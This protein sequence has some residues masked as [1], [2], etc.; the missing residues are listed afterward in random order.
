MKIIGWTLGIIILLI[1]MGVLGHRSFR[2]WQERRLGAQANALVTEGDLKRASLDARRILQINPESAEGC[3]IMARI[4]ERGGSRTA[5]EWRRRVVELQPGNAE[6][7]IALARAAIKFDDQGSR[8]FALSRLPKAAKTTPEYQ[9]LAADMA[10]A[11]KDPHA[12]EKHLQEAVRLEPQNKEHQLRLAALQLG[13]PDAETAAAAKRT[14]T[15]L[16][17]EPLHRLEA[18]RRLIQDALRGKDFEEAVTVGRQL[19][20]LPE[21]VFD[22]RLLLLSALNGVVHPEVTPLLKELKAAAAET[23]ERVADLIYWLN[24]NQRPAAAIS[25][26]AQ[27]PPERLTQRGVPVALADS[28]VA[29]RDWQGMQRIVKEGSWGSLDFLRSALAARAARE[30]GDRA[31]S[32]VLWSEAVKKVSANP[33]QALTLAEVV[34]RWGWRTEAVDLLWIAAKD[35]ADGDAALQVLY[36]YFATDGDS[37]DL[38]R[39]LLHRQQFRPDDLDVQ[40][41]LAQLSL[42]LNLNVDRGQK[43]AR[44]LF[45]KDS[46]NPAYVSTYAFALHAAGDTRKAVKTM[47]A[48]GAERLR[49]PELAAY[50]GIFLV[51]AGEGARAREFL[52]LGETATLLPE[53]RALVEKARRT[54]AQR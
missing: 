27:L 8:D 6:D 18:S 43:L 21:R 7:L 26:A 13:S 4:S 10:L 16:Q 49:H 53:E 22:D 45:E 11:R 38:Y 54:V 35:P 14:L 33:R 40:N 47:E 25:W 39:V 12:A 50:F 32:G 46:A 30:L 51:A 24:A 48:L 15:E 5:I 34:N 42:L 19:D 36:N 17:Q 41:N 2:N 28:Y 37:Q 9:A 3:R 52:D 31:G 20:A 29:A 23:P 44:D 1:A